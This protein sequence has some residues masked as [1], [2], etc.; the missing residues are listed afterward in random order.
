LRTVSRRGLLR[1]LLAMGF[2]GATSGA[3]AALVEPWIRLRTQAY[4]L[5]PP[6]WPAGRTLRIVAL[7]DLHFCRPFM[8]ERRGAEIVARANAL[9]PDLVVL[10]GDYSHGRLIGA[11]PM[12]PEIWSKLLAGL[13]APL[14]VHAI[15]GNHD[16]W[17]DADAMARRDGPTQ[18][19]EALRAAGIRVHENDAVLLHKDG[20][21]FWLAGLGDQWAFH[22]LPRDGR[23]RGRDDMD[24]L[25]SRVTTSDPLI[26]MAHEPDVFSEA[27]DRVCLTLSGHTHGGQVRLFGFAPVVPSAFGRRYVYGHIQE[28]G[29]HLVVSGGLGCSILPLRLGSPPEIV[30]LELGE[31]QDGA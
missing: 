7:A 9:R 10:L 5:T 6:G 29:R 31:A 4:R 24:L 28:S 11:Q 17:D 30:V 14:G 3:Y 8:S 27:T 13:S 12:E 1:A 2:L 25:L 16:W 20:F 23:P 15:L 19:G 18:A 22:V 26:L 21:S